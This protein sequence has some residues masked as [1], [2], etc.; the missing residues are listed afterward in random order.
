MPTMTAVDKIRMMIEGMYDHEPR[1]VQEVLGEGDAL[2]L[3]YDSGVFVEGIG[4]SEIH[5]HLSR[6]RVLEEFKQLSNKERCWQVQIVADTG[7]KDEEVDIVDRY[8]E[9][10]TPYKK[11]K[12]H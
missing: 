1:N 6:D 5:S 10:P 8:M 11:R 4:S 2:S 3:C 9:P 7:L 12:L